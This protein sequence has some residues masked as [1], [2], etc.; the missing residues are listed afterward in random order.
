ML[1]DIHITY[2][3]EVKFK[4]V[5]MGRQ[6]Q[7]KSQGNIPI[8]VTLPESM[9]KDLHLYISKRQISK[10]VAKMVEKGLELE[11][12]K[13]AREFREASLD[14]ERAAEIE[15][16]DTLSGEGLSETNSY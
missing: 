13:L 11:K 5:A 16:W 9:V 8:T 4:E 14:E 7:Q 15:L 1:H 12:E 2:T 10:F 6:Y 3:I